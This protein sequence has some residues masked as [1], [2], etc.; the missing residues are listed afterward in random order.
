MSDLYNIN[1]ADNWKISLRDC[2]I[3]SFDDNINKNEIYEKTGLFYMCYAPNYL[4]KYYSGTDRNIDVVK[5]NKMWYSAP[6]S[7]NDV[8]DSDIATDE[9][10]LF[11][12]SL[13]LAS[14][15]ISIRKG[16]PMWI[17]L[18]N[19]VRTELKSLCQTFEEMKKTTGITCLSEK[20]DSLL[21][22]AHYANN[23]RGICVE[24]ELL[25]INEQLN[26][27]PVPIIY[28]NDRAVY[29]SIDDNPIEVFIKSL[30]SKSSEWSYEKEWRIIQDDKACGNS[31]DYQK[32]GALLDMITPH[33]IILGCMVNPEFE[34]DMKEY[35]EENEINL[36]KMEKDPHFYKLIKTPVLE[37]DE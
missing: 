34:K 32:N 28:D 6:I 21:M 29:S 8:F 31:W 27:A 37:F 15:D 4:Y 36:Y 19:K 13:K 25:E 17:Q 35:C 9:K 20:Y 12:S 30:T 33:S 22:W 18:K 10:A 24:Y 16:S 26:F 1:D 23:H 2:I 14:R 5:S 7:F 11:N 3:N